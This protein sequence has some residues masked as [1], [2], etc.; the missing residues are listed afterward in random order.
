VADDVMA[1]CTALLEAWAFAASARAAAQLWPADPT[2]AQGKIE[3]MRYGAQWLL[4]S[5]QLH[6]QRVADAGR[7][8]LPPLRVIG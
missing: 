1:G 2:W 5:A 4:P 6:W 8:A 7:Q 3:R